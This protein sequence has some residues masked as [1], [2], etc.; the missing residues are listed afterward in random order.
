MIFSRREDKA[1]IRQQAEAVGKTVF[2]LPDAFPA[3]IP[4]LTN[5]STPREEKE[6]CRFAT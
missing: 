5:G 3:P 4:S 1:G 6:T 2:L